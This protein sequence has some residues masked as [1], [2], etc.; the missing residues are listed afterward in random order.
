MSDVIVI[1]TNDVVAIETPS[2]II[3]EVSGPQGP[4]GGNLDW[5]TLPNKPATFPPSTHSHPASQI[6][7][8]ATAVA[9]VVPPESV[10]ILSSST[11]PTEFYSS[12]ADSL[13]IAGNT[14]DFTVLTFGTPLT[15][16]R[17]IQGAT[18]GTTGIR[19]VA[20]GSPSYNSSQI[21]AGSISRISYNGGGAMN[22]TLISRVDHGNIAF[23]GS[24][25]LPIATTSVN[26]LMT[27]SDKTKLNGIAAGAEANVKAD[28]NATTGDEEIL[29]KPALPFSTYKGDYDNGGDYA[30]G[31]VVSTPVGSPYGEPNQLFTR[32]SNPG[33]PGYPPGTSSWS[34]VYAASS[35]THTA[36][37]ILE[38]RQTFNITSTNPAAPTQLDA[39]LA[40][41]DIDGG[42]DCVVVLNNTT[43]IVY[44]DIMIPELFSPS[45][46]GRIVLRATTSGLGDITN[47]RLLIED[48]II[49]PASGYAEVDPA[50][51]QI[52][53]VW[54]D[55]YWKF[56][57]EQ[58]DSAF[59]IVGGTDATKKVAFEVDT[60]VSTATT[61]TLT[62]PNSSGTIALLTNLPVASTTTPAALGTAAVG[63]GTTFARADHVHA[64]PTAASTGAAQ[65]VTDIELNVND[66]TAITVGQL[67]ARGIAYSDGNALY[68]VN[69]P[70]PSK[71]QSGLTFSLKRENEGGTPGDVFV[72]V[73]HAGVNLL[74][75]YEVDENEG[76]T[77]FLWNGYQWVYDNVSTLR[78]SSTRVL[79][80][81]EGTG[82]L[83]LTSHSH[84]AATTTAAGFL[85]ASDKTKLD[86]VAAGAEVNANADWNATTGDA[87]ILNKPVL[88]GVVTDAFPTGFGIGIATIN[89]A[90]AS[91]WSGALGMTAGTTISFQNV[92]VGKTITFNINSNGLLASW[93][94]G[95]TWVGGLA[96]ST[97]DIRVRILATSATTFLGYADT[98][99]ASSASY[100]DLVDVPAT[101]TPTSHTHPISD[102]TNLQTALNDKAA[103]SHTHPASQITSF[104]IELVVACSDET[105]NLTVG[106]NKVTFRAPCAFTLTGV[107]AS[108]N[109]APTGSALIVDLNRNGAS[110]IQSIGAVS[111]LRIDAGT[112]SS[113]SSSQPTLVLS[114]ITIANDAEVTIDIDQVGS[115]I[116]GKGL[117][118][119]LIGTR[120]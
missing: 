92:I 52:V 1:D 75:N 46:S 33:N 37:E 18:T 96:P 118:V 61:R 47:F 57:D 25:S 79:F 6:T 12:P 9:A 67:P 103:S 29:N 91:H 73:V 32:V 60:L 90:L 100:T 99:L 107:R 13:W 77:D 63:T 106:S 105:S 119:V 102:V 44:A 116:A 69:L 70:T 17:Y 120:A 84:A 58:P 31:D 15:G 22:T 68:T 7:D 3:L 11:T 87:Q 45:R 76:S 43:G 30:I 97:T 28:W 117:K 64:M 81:P 66:P 42:I 113:L 86:G 21:P 110:V 16:F 82:T 34:S 8:F 80:L 51:P 95:I 40:F 55:S 19:I 35:H 93:P 108:V 94:A 20:S 10:Y 2:E 5:D 65:A 104:P 62:V 78:G 71:R 101:F 98:R 26:G 109:T 83:A 89:W 4:A 14:G 50:S 59:R 27:G 48:N 38:A 85:S 53:L 23:T 74:T 41:Q 39:A 72:T 114:L 49:Y 115:T 111:T 24:T 112:K 36:N 56:E 88:N 54:K